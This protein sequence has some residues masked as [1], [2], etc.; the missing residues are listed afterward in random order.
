M[1]LKFIY[2]EKTG[3]NVIIE[4]YK[5]VEIRIHKNYR[6]EKEKA[7]AKARGYGK[8]NKDFD[9]SVDIIIISLYHYRNVYQDPDIMYVF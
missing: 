7:Y 4:V 1:Q 9:R 8:R 5:Y 2:L 6:H 3:K